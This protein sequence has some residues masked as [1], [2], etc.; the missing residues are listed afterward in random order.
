MNEDE[1]L[2]L[3]RVLLAIDPDRDLE[4]E[5]PTRTELGFLAEVLGVFRMLRAKNRAYGDSAMDPVRVFSRADPLEQIRVR[6]DDKLSR[7]ARGSGAG[8]DVTL[9]LIGYLVLLRVAEKDEH[10]VEDPEGL[11]PGGFYEAPLT[12]DEEDL[13]QE[14]D[15]RYAAGLT[16]RRAA[17]RE[18]A[19]AK[20]VYEPF[21]ERL[22]GYPATNL[23]STGAEIDQAY[24]TWFR[25]RA[26]Q[27]QAVD[28]MDYES[29]WGESPGS[30][31]P[32]ED[33]DGNL[34]R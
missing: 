5:A 8:E 13:F 7:L 6:I 20:G 9:D 3:G 10:G 33:D 26:A 16:D 31:D 34:I 4:D 1:D 23:E 27:E 19:P 14:A 22:D 32:L 29:F 21:R 2:D 30:P 15:A 24:R 28:G 17:A 25:A 12:E 11:Y 18:E